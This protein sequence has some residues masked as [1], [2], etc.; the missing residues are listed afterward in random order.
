MGINDLPLYP[1]AQ[2]GHHLPTAGD[3]WGGRLVHKQSYRPRA[4]SDAVGG[5]KDH[6]IRPSLRWL[7]GDQAGVGVESQ[8]GRQADRTVRVNAIL[9]DDPVVERTGRRGN[10]ETRADPGGHRHTG[11]QTAQRQTVTR[12]R[13]NRHHVAQLAGHCRLASSVVAPP[14]DFGGGVTCQRWDGHSKG[15]YQ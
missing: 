14:G 11:R 1:A 9:G 10:Q 8:A 6:C 4:R 3:R 2:A 5:G 7:S 12:S 15:D 13:R